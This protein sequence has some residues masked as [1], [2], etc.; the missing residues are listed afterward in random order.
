MEEYIMDNDELYVI[1]A[2][3]NELKF[4]GASILSLYQFLYYNNCHE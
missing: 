4:N 2:E 3:F 1:G